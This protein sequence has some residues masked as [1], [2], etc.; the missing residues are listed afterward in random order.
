MPGFEYVWL[1]RLIPDKIFAKLM[2]IT[3]IF[4]VRGWY[5]LA[6][7]LAQAGGFCMWRSIWYWVW[8]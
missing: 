7:R 3:V 4:V 5:I 8:F 1:L 6:N 2:N